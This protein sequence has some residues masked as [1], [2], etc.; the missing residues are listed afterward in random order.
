[1]GGWKLIRHSGSFSDRFN[2][3]PTGTRQEGITC[4]IMLEISDL[5]FRG[6]ILPSH[7]VG[8]SI[9]YVVGIFSSPLPIL[10]VH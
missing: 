8:E 4:P 1:M 5:S 9:P 7:N 3:I 2:P 6:V 10:G